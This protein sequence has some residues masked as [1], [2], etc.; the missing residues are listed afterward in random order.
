MTKNNTYLNYLI[1]LSV[2]LERELSEKWKSIY[3]AE[4]FHKLLFITCL[5]WTL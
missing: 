2:Q 1:N 5:L 3:K 4:Q